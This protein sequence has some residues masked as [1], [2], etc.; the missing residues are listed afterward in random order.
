L[1]VSALI[2]DG[3]TVSEA[4]KQKIKKDISALQAKGIHPKLTAV[5][6]GADPASKV[7]IR[8]KEKGCEE[9]GISHETICLP[10]STPEVEL[11]N[12]VLKLNHDPSVSGILVQL[13]LPKHINE[14]IIINT[15]SPGK[16]V[17]CFHPF[18]V[19]QL[20]LGESIFA[21]CT[22]AGVMELLKYYNFDPSGKHVVI[23]GRSNIVGKPLANLLI[24][25][26]KGANAVVTLC[27][28]GA[29]DL[30]YY[31]LQADI[32]IAAVGKPRVITSDMVKNGAIVIDVGINRIADASAKSGSRMVG[33]VDFESVKE[34]AAAITP[35]PG[36]VGPMTIAVL[37]K[38]TI[39][40]AELLSE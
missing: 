20:M 16:D 18:N 17:D 8:N 7:Y 21:P 33:D 4:I 24:Q 35:V 40:A 34:V 14:K 11:E 9:T 38:N 37:L 25:K 28:T 13:P 22:P 10:E 1:D 26:A 27:H 36:G 6:V 30:R 31:T 3:K 2:I 23:V 32:L 15:I 39:K 29:S 19:G 5:L 12:L